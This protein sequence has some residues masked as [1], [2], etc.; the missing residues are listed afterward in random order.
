MTCP[1]SSLDT[2]VR[3]F[4]DPVHDA[5]ST[6]RVLLDTLARPGTIGSIDVSLDDNVLCQWPAAAFA[7]MLTLADFSTPIWLQRHD[8]GLA[9][10]LRFHTGAPLAATPGE[11]AFAYLANGNDVPALNAF[12]LGTPEAPHNSATLL[13]RADALEGGRRITLSGPGIETSAAVAPI[14]IS[15]TFWRERAALQAQ[16]PCG[17]DCYLV[18]G[19]SVIG[20]SRT[21]RVEVD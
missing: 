2:L 6:F 12:S 17:V 16:A 1:P 8:E 15:G 3:G 20:I 11:A 5:Q 13:I 7:A 14:G 4:A 19:R 18:C 9:Q 21:T 10:A